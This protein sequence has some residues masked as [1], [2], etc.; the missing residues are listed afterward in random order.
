VAA[1]GSEDQFCA[2]SE[3]GLNLGMAFQITDDLLDIIGDEGRE[4]KTLGT[5][6]AQCKPTLPIIHLLTTAGS[7]DKSDLIEK[8]SGGDNPK[9]LAEMLENAGSTEFA[10]NMAQQLCKKATESLGVLGVG[11]AKDSLA[12]IADFVSRRSG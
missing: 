2:L 12:E 5:D 9:Q 4:G 3:Y 11:S 1:T 7:Q 8:L 10:R 6:F